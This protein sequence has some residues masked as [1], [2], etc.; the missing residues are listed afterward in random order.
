MNQ[1]QALYEYLLRLGDNALILGQRLT[2]WI[3]HAPAL[4][5]ELGSANVALDLIGQARGWLAYAGTVEGAGRDEDTLALQRDVLDFRN[6]LLLEQP[7]GHYGDTIARQYLFDAFHYPLLEALRGC[8]DQHIA[9][10]AAKSYKEAGYHRRRSAE[11]MVRLGDGT[12]ESHAKL[13]RS[14]DTLWPYTG[15]LFTP[16]EVDRT[17]QSLGVAADLT[18][19]YQTW[20]EDV[21]RT[22][23]TATLQRPQAGWMQSGGK[24]GRHSEQLGYILAQ[25]QFLPRA[26]PDARW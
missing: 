3:G 19:V 14:V 23:K 21:A 26:Y 16:D 1:R 12:A 7:N 25:M 13:Q 4:E 8:A 6:A 17:L 9:A 11:W 5:E 20:D 24:Q 15:E 2:E 10:I 18:A 22:L